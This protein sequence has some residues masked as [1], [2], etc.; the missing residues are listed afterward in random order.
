MR[1]GGGPPGPIATAGMLRALAVTT[2]TRSDA[3][4]EISTVGDEASA[5]YGIGAP[6]NTPVEVIE[7]LNKEVNAVAADPTILP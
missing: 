3:M 2:A 6:R 7:K 1:L 4:L 5:W